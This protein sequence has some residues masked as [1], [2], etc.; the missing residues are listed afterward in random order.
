[1]IVL[2]PAQSFEVLKNL[3]MIDWYAKNSD[4]MVEYLVKS[5]LTKEAKPLSQVKI[6]VTGFLLFS[7]VVPE[8]HFVGSSS[9]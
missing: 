7:F 6:F 1:M 5:A 2:G 8:Q 9:I 4:A 3:A